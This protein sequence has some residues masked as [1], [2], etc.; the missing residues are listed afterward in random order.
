MINNVFILYYLEILGRDWIGKGEKEWY[1]RCNKYV[2][3]VIF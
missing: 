3:F 2:W 1:G